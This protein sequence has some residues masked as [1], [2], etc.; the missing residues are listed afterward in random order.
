MKGWMMALWEEAEAEV[1]E[2]PKRMMERVRRIQEEEVV[3]AAAE[4]A[5]HHRSQAWKLH[6]RQVVVV[7]AEAAAA[8]EEEDNLYSNLFLGS[9]HPLLN[10]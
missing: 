8:E 3:A 1:A 5:A 7:V 10:R 4:V 6:L 9:Q 2:G